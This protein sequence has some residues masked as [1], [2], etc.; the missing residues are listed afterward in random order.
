MTMCSKGFLVAALLS[1]ALAPPAQAQGGSPP[2]SQASTSDVV[3]VFLDQA[4]Y[5]R[6]KNEP[7]QADEALSRVLAID[8]NNV[9]ALAG[10][11]QAAVGP[12]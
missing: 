6:N 1:A 8:P 11:A 2:V 4:S 10:Q 5:W 12:R 7:A 9:D 3:R